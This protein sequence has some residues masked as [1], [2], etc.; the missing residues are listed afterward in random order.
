VNWALNHHLVL[1]AGVAEDQFD[2]A[3]CSAD[4]SFFSELERTILTKPLT[5]H[6]AARGER[7][8]TAPVCWASG[9][10]WCGVPP[11][12]LAALACLTS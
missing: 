2:S 6:G 10:R 5:L 8:D 3:Y 11:M 4:V 9:R 1:Q 7:R 12:V